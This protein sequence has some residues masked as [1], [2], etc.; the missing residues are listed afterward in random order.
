MPVRAYESMTRGPIS[1]RTR[2]ILSAVGAMLF[3]VGCGSLTAATMYLVWSLTSRFGSEEESD[4]EGFNG[5][6]DDNSTPKKVGYVA[7]PDD[8]IA[9]IKKAA[10]EQAKIEATGN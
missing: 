7:I 2:D 3:G 8:D 6:D 5:E 10:Q 4:D 9:A 1:E